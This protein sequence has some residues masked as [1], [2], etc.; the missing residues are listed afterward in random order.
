MSVK[1][2]IK[3]CNSTCLRPTTVRI[4]HLTRFPREVA[5]RLRFMMIVHS[6]RVVGN[7]LNFTD[8]VV[9]MVYRIITQIASSMLDFGWRHP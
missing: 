3:D 1:D 4:T 7:I 6:S 9:G 5:I 8:F 2:K